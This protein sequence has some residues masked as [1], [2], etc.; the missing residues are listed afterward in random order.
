MQEHRF[1]FLEEKPSPLSRIKPFLSSVGSFLN[2]CFDEVERLDCPPELSNT[3]PITP[4]MREVYKDMSVQ[5]L[6]LLVP[7]VSPYGDTIIPELGLNGFMMRDEAMR[8]DS[9]P[10][11]QLDAEIT[12][13]IAEHTDLASN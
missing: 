2:N 6:G 12:K 10:Q 11:D 1:D 3:G 9:L 5:R 7:Q 4:E 13:F 8:L